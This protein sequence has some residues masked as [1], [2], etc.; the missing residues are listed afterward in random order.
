M[1]VNN[2]GIT[3]D[4]LIMRMKPDQWN[5]VI[6]TNLTGVF[7][8]TQVA[9]LQAFGCILLQALHLRSSTRPLRDLDRHQCRVS[10]GGYLMVDNCAGSRQD[11]VKEEEG[12]HHQHHLCGWGD[13]KCWAGKLCSSKGD[14]GKL[15]AVDGLLVVEL[16]TQT[17]GGAA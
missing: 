3:R 7:F 4:S 13:R 12:P 6:N 5:A 1:L 15:L 17:Y 10:V 8:A 2:A 14:P 16:A 9:S 11:H